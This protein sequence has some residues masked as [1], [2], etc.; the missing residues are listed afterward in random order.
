MMGW[1]LVQD[2]SVDEQTDILLFFLFVSIFFFIIQYRRL[3]FKE[4]NVTYTDDQFQEAV[5]RTASELEW[6]IDHK[7]KSFFRAYRFSNWTASWGEMIT[8]IRDK[9]RLFINS[10]CDPNKR[11]SIA[12]FGWNIKNIKTFAKNLADVLNNKPAEQKIE[13]STV[14]WSMKKI[15]FRLFMYPFCIFLIV[16]GVYMII[17][18]Q[19]INTIIAGLGAMALASI[20]L[21]LDIKIFMTKRGKRN[22]TNF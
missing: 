2:E 10:I 9:D 1:I 4:F 20:Y 8:I 5:K 21:F 13:L 6:D 19:S 18:P 12:S 15:A 22:S 16:F 3:N 7:S 11:S 17:N 14:E